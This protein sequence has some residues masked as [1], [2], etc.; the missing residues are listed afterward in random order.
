MICRCGVCFLFFIGKLLLRRSYIWFCFPLLINYYG[1]KAKVGCYF[2]I[3]H[4]SLFTKLVNG[5]DL[6][7]NGIRFFV[8]LLLQGL[9]LKNV[10]VSVHINLFVYPLFVLLLP[11]RTPRWAVLVSSFCLGLLVDLF[12]HSAGLNAAA[13]TLTAFLREWVLV[14]LEPRGGY[15]HNFSPTRQRQGD[16]WFWQYAALLMGIHLAFYFVAETFTVFPLGGFLL[17]LVLSFAFSVVL[18]VL[19][20]YLVLNEKRR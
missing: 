13:L 10:Q 11:L 19:S 17:R 15:A 9:I 12:Y 5:N 18:V 6:L 14:F 3:F 4:F 8:L 20:Q 7:P 16:V 2:F 1:V